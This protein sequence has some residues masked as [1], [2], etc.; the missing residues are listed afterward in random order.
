MQLLRMV[1]LLLTVSVLPAHLSQ[2]VAPR[3][4]QPKVSL[5]EEITKFQR[6]GGLKKAEPIQKAA[7]EQLD[8]AVARI[9]ANR[10]VIAGSDSEDSTDSDD[11]DFF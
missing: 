7:N 9:L 11:S 3:P 2:K 8:D 5:M 1:F 4:V 10:G 6:T